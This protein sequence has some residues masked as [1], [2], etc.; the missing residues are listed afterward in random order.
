MVMHLQ[1]HFLTLLKFESLL[2]LT[3]YTKLLKNYEPARKHIK[4]AFL[5]IR[6]GFHR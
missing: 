6:W 1:K 2:S 5:K 3:F 4:I